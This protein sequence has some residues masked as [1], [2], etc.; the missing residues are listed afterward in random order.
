MN[1]TSTSNAL[2]SA[3]NI[4]YYDKIADRYEAIL[5]NDNKNEVIRNHVSK[6]FVARVKYGTVLDFG[7]GTGLDFNWLL[8]HQFEIIFCEPSASM[9]GRARERRDGEFPGSPILFL[10]EDKTDFRKWDGEFPLR[11]R[12]NAV[13]ANFAVFNCIP[14][15][16]LLF[17]KLALSLEAEGVVIALILES[18][19]KKR[20]RSNFK[21]TV[22]SF[23]SRKPVE[24]MI[25]ENEER[26]L[27]YLHTIR[28]IRRAATD[29]FHFIHHERLT[30]LGF[31]LIHL[32]KK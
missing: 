8:K 10:D 32:V 11:Q 7:G 17:E 9:R 25:E 3:G 18:R 19:L 4:S 16:H 24:L 27:V 30:G 5:K 29:R 12:I 15:I 23:F 31:S 28:A 26:Q 2:I 1:W 13:L 20:L 22:M 6:S 21:G 14:D